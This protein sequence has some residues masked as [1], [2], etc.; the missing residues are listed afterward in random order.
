MDEL[1]PKLAVLRALAADEHVTRAAEAAGVPQP[2]VSRWLAAVGARLGAPVVRRDGRRVRLTR[3]GRLLAEAADRAAAVLE[4]GWRAA[5]EEVDPERGQVALGFLHLLGRSLVPELVRGFRERHPH[6]RF[7]LVQDSR[8]AVL[9][10][11]AAGVVDLALVAP[12][13]EDPEFASAVLWSQEVLL[14]VP[15]DHRLARRAGVRVAELAEEEFV[16][17]EHGYGLRQITDDLCRAAGFT[18][19]LAFEG[20]ETET[21]RGLVAAGLGVALLPPAEH[22]TGLVEVPLTP[23]ARR[24]I[25]LVWQADQPL[26]PAVRAF[27]DHALGS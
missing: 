16:G 23:P 12:P 21:V 20:Q 18:P 11:L 3:A 9:D 2:T 10:H 15:A 1:A 25:G 8:Q 7:R 17:L 26:P 24:Q 22:P 14:V 27:R 19:R 13:P 6:V 4:A 5:A